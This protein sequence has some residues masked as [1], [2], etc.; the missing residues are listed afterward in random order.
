MLLSA[1]RPD[2]KI[3]TVKGFVLPEVLV[4]SVIFILI[5][6]GSWSIY[7]MTWRWWK[8]TLPVIEAQR[9]ARLTLSSVMDGMKDPDAG[10]DGSFSRRN[11]VA[12][13]VY[14]PIV[15]GSLGTSDKISFGLEKEKE[16]YGDYPVAHN[17]RSFYMGVD[18]VTSRK[19]VYYKGSDG[20]SHPI[21]STLGITGLK[22]EKFTDANNR[23]LL[24]VTASSEKTIAGARSASYTVKR[25]YTESAYLRNVR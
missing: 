22:F 15:S 20:V 6:G 14:D 25:E 24:M 7:Y 12:W 18:G 5:F 9:V 19:I 17:I 1:V 16:V 13:A 21:K 4:A 11:G 8:E 2:I 3:K 10:A 23:I